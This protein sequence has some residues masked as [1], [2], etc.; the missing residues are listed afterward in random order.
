VTGPT[1]ELSPTPLVLTRARNS[2]GPTPIPNRKPAPSSTYK[3]LQTGLE[4]VRLHK[5]STYVTR[6]TLGRV[7]ATPESEADA[8]AEYEATT[9]KD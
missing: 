4:P 7:S 2:L 8:T 3:S 9:L 5:P 6:R 1:P